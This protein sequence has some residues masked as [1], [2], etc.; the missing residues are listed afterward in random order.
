LAVQITEVVNDDGFIFLPFYSQVKY[1]IIKA[2]ENMEVATSLCELA[3]QFGF[4]AGYYKFDK[5]YETFF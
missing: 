4:T 5:N 3:S 2:K 1:A